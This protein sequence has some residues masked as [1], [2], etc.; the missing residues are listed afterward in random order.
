MEPCYLEYRTGLCS[1]DIRGLFSRRTCCCTVGRGWGEKCS[2]CPRQD[3]QEFLSL[4][5]DNPELINECAVFPGI[6]LHGRCRNTLQSFQCDCQ[7]G[8]ALDETGFRS[9]S[10]LF[11]FRTLYHT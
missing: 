11:M 9:V 5:G 10:L 1:R 7:P 8:F 3:S 6:C 2:A 4:C